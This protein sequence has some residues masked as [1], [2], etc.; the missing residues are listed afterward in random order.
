MQAIILAAGR[1]RRLW[2]LTA[3]SPKCLLPL[4]G[5]P[6][7]AHQLDILEH[8]GVDDALIVCGGGSARIR[9]A[10]AAWTG[11]LR[12]RC[13][14]NPLA[15]V[16]DNLLSLWTARR[17]LADDLILVNGDVVFHP[18]LL[19]GLLAVA[20]S[21]TLAVSRQ[22]SY[23]E[24]DMKVQ[25]RDGRVIRVGKDLPVPDADAT[26]VGVMRFT[27]AGAAALRHSLESVVERPQACRGYFLEAVQW[28]V[29]EGLPV[30]AW[31]CGSLPW[32]DVDTPEDLDRVQ[33]LGHRLG[34]ANPVSQ[35]AGGRS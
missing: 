15:T 9:D 1:G 32:V 31:D 27:G 24:D 13:W 17:V 23:S 35:A 5:R 20:G 4:H 33:T 10:L 3:D 8:H 34:M 2:P 21:G 12:P 22:T 6:L 18:D 25:M 16:S 7:L 28:L 30:T 26:S 14:Y 11:S 29:D 19:A